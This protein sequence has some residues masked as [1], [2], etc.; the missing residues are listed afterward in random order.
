MWCRTNTSEN[1]DQ[2]SF[3]CGESPLAIE[4]LSPSADLSSQSPFSSSASS[5]SSSSSLRVLVGFFLLC[6]VL[7]PGCL[8]SPS[9]MG[10]RNFPL[11]W[12]GNISSAS[13]LLMYMSLEFSAFFYLLPVSYK[14]VSAPGPPVFLVVTNEYSGQYF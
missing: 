2:K 11:S 8:R 14:H 12:T 4:S 9:A 7:P 6:L 13:N 3:S 5:S 10:N 1:N